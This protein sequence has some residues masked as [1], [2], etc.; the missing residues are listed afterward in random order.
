[1][2]QH[3][4]QPTALSTD[5][6]AVRF[7]GTN[8]SYEQGMAEMREAMQN[9]AVTGPQLLLLEHEDVITTTRQ[10]KNTHL[11]TSAEALKEARIKLIETDR[12]GDITFHGKGQ[13]VGYPILQLSP[14]KG[15]LDYV[16]ALENALQKVCS[17]L[18]IV[19]T[20]CLPG[21]TGVWVKNQNTGAINKLI[22][23]GIG[24][25][26]G[27]TRHGFAFNLT[28]DL[29]RFTK[30]IVP[31]GLSD[32]GVTSLQQELG[33]SNL[34]SQQYVTRILVEEIE[35]VLIAVC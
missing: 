32:F 22:A 11:L 5:K 27:V 8:V 7:L 19:N 13:L 6:F 10:H 30:H 4:L 12:G 24:I 15:P 34:P 23:I 29:P 26:K 3:L 14:V 20:V 28:T 1:M 16:R 35:Q 31:C 18:G 33:L 21:K 17:R 25:S 2:K 9:V